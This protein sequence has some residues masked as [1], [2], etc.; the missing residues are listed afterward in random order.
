MSQP[1][2][3]ARRARSAPALVGVAIFVASM[4]LYLATIAPTLTWG[5]DDLGVDGGEFLVAAKTLGVPH[6]PGYPTYML[7]LRGFATFLPV[8]DFAF[9][10]NLLSALLAA[11]SALLIYATA[12]RLARSIK[13]DAPDG[14]AVA[15][16]AIGAASFAAAP[17]LWSQAVIT[18]VYTLNALFAASLVLIAVQVV[19][20]PPTE[21][22]VA[23]RLALFG[24]LLGLGL[25]NHMTLLAVAV[26]MLAWIALDAGW[27]RLATPWL[28]V[29]F[30]AGLSVYIYL[31]IRAAADPPINWGGADTLRGA[32]WLLT[33]RA[34]SDYVFGVAGDTLVQRLV[35]WLELMFTQFNPLGLFFGLVGARPFLSQLPRFFYASLAIIVLVS[36][37]S[38][39]FNSVDFQVLMVPALLVFSIWIGVGFFW[40]LTT[41]RTMAEDREDD[42]GLPRLPVS[43]ARQ[44]AALTVLAFVLV[45]GMSVVLNY[46]SQ[47]LSDDRTAVEYARQVFDSVPD[48]SVVLSEREKNVFSLWYQGYVEEPDRDVAVV[49]TRLLQ[50]DWYWDDVRSRFPERL[51]ATDTNVAK[52]VVH[53]VEHN[54]GAAP[55]FTTFNPRLTAPSTK[56][57]SAEASVVG[58]VALR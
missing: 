48:G 24:L 28:I 14:L 18:E 30:V 26:P 5:W 50:F 57:P 10:G 58:H 19:G 7:L 54:R 44:A 52:A 53:I 22:G 4:A 41:L 15:G 29:P 17:L 32:A 36:V 21:R 13:P 51:P 33:A 12:L 46:T 56:S 1:A 23:A 20:E 35:T 40:I 25:G 37:Y 16:A 31:P 55:V 39:T 2:T 34:Y 11:G 27:R 43:P 6:P 42:D 9:R 3:L 8:G 47:D 45:P 49:S 38:V